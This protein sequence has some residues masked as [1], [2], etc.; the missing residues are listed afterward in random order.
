MRF[1]ADTMTHKKPMTDCSE[2]ICFPFH[3]SRAVEVQFDAPEIS[4]NAGILLLRQVDGRIGLCAKVAACLTDTRDASRVSHDRVE[5]VR[6][7]AFQIAM[8]YEDC[9]DADTMRHDRVL[10]V[11][12]DRNIDAG[13]LSSQPTLSRF[14][15]AITGKELN[16]IV[17]VL[18]QEYVNSLADDTRCVVLDI[19]ST[20]D[21]THGQQQ[22]TFF[23]GF[24]G[25]WMY[26]P[27]LVFDDD[28]ELVTLL[29][30]PGNAHGARGSR[31][32]LTRVIRLIKKRFPEA[33][34]VV[35]GDAA[36]S[37][38]GLLDRVDALRDELGEVHYIVGIATNSRLL[39]LSA[40]A[41]QTAA[42]WHGG[43]MGHVRHFDQF[44]YAAGT[45][46]RSRTIVVKAEHSAYGENPRFIVTSL[47]DIAPQTLYDVGYCARGHAENRI[48]DFKNALFGD[49][50]SCGKFVANF[51]R[52]LLHAVAYRLMRTLR[53]SLAKVDPALGALQFDSIRL[54][55]L[56]VAAIV[57]QSARCFLVRLPIAF[58][59]ADVFRALARRL[60]VD[61]P[62]LCT[63]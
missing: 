14:E 13:G 9:N 34:I 38:P 29:L 46:S 27:L 39:A 57:T 11:A 3:R 17:N 63:D 58:P 42:Q 54:R 48:K 2:A 16:A 56:K 12:C 35:R 20:A 62:E 21:K 33:Q 19:D 31:M 40:P 43:G 8:G 6:Q 44:Q 60:I 36:F 26:H 30:R 51:F 10:N 28:G 45:W 18:E 41:R 53:L 1:E 7:R 52:L 47:D 49:R 61:T 32:M 25:R 50:L 24:Y 15:N 55:L 22:L 23:H 4:S 5:Q 37:I 59:L